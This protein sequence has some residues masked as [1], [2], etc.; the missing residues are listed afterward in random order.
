MCVDDILIPS[1]LDMFSMDV[2]EKW[3]FF[4]LS[5]NSNNYNQS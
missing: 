1:F 5:N 3:G 2:W 4:L